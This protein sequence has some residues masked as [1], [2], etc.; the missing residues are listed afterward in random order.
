MSNKYGTCQCG[1]KLEAVW[2][3]EEET[4]TSGGI[5]VKTGRTRKACSHLTC[6]RCLTNVIVDDSFDGPF[7]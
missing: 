1:E 5:M 3:T 2:F 4:N 7:Q 6:P